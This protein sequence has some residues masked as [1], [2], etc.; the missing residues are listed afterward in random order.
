[1]DTMVKQHGFTYTV[2]AA[3]LDESDPAYRKPAPRDLVLSLAR[4]KRD[5]LIQRHRESLPPAD[6]SGLLITC[7]QVVVCEG[8]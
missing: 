4:A 2:M 1:M 5:A 8:E 6:F 7:D 3:D